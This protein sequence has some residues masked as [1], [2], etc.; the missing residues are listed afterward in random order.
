MWGCMG[1]LFKGMAAGAAEAF[2]CVCKG[3]G[4]G[5]PIRYFWKSGICKFI[6]ITVVGLSSFSDGPGVSSQG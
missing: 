1:V 3:Q 5:L 6:T 2:R 4:Q